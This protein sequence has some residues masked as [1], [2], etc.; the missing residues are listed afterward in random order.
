MKAIDVGT[1]NT[2]SLRRDNTQPPAMPAATASRAL[3][4][5]R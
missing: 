2:I 5:E 4:R 3:R 1:A